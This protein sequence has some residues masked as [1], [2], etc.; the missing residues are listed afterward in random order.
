[1]YVITYDITS[2]NLVALAEPL[3]F[4]LLHTTEN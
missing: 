2:V 1:M 4:H 3:K